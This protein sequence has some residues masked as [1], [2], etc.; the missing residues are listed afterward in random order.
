MQG[1]PGLHRETLGERKGEEGENEREGGGGRG[2]EK[3]GGREG[4]GEDRFSK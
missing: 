1:Q 3:R 4:E 2:V